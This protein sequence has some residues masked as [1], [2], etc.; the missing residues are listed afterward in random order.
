MT[1]ITLMVI[2][3]IIT[4]HLH[5]WQY[6]H[7]QTQRY[8]ESQASIGIVLPLLLAIYLLTSKECKQQY[9]LHL[10]VIVLWRLY[11]QYISGKSNTSPESFVMTNMV[12]WIISRSTLFISWRRR[13]KHN[14]IDLW[15]SDLNIVSSGA[16]AL[17]FS[18]ALCLGI[19]AIFGSLQYLFDLHINREYM[20]DIV[21]IVMGIGWTTTFLARTTHHTITDYPKLLELFAK[22]ILTGLIGIYAL[23]LLSY[24]VKIIFTGVWPKGMVVYMVIGYFILGFATTLILYP[25]QHEPEKSRITTFS[26]RFYITSLPILVLWFFSLKIRV[27]QYGWTIKRYMVVALL[28]LFITLG[29]SNI[30]SKKYRTSWLILTIMIYGVI[31]LLPK[32]GFYDSILSYHHNRIDTILHN[33]HA[34]DT[35]WRY[36]SGTILTGQSA[37]DLASSLEY[38][39][40]HYTTGD[41]AFLGNYE[42]TLATIIRSEYQYNLLDSVKNK[43]WLSQISYNHIQDIPSINRYNS[44]RSQYIDLE[45]YKTLYIINYPGND[46]SITAELDLQTSF[47]GLTFTNHGQISTLSF[48][49][50]FNRFATGNYVGKGSENHIEILSGKDYKALITELNAYKD[51]YRTINN[52]KLYLFLR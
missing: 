3:G 40:Y 14:D 32:I 4:N 36:I 38:L 5:P 43:F 39:I 7:D 49:S 30:M 21:W 24:A 13:V 42:P 52:Y 23:I 20:T 11:F 8:F 22:Y 17:I 34:L 18:G 33:S 27:D 25:L 51:P 47:N 41:I 35:Q 9:L 12:L 15:F 2:V 37:N 29:I 28:L 26:K 1:G 19:A 46:E 31:V 10:V 6:G 48:T 44:S 45:D 16:V 50:I